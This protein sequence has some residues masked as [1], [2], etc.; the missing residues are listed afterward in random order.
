MH[1]DILIC[2]DRDEGMVLKLDKALRGSNIRFGP[3]VRNQSEPVSQNL[4]KGA[5]MLLCELPPSNFDDFDCLKWIQLTSAGYAQ[6]LDLPVLERGIRVTN[7]L[8]NFDVPIAEWNIAMMVHCH[9]HIMDMFDNQRKAVWDNDARFQGEIRG[10]VV[11][12]YGYGGIAR[13]TARM[14]KHMGLEVW[15]MTRDGTAKKRKDIYRVPGTGDPEGIL[16]DR[17][18]KPSQIEEF[19]S[20]VDFLMITMPLTPATEGIIGEKELRML[21]PSAVL[22]NPARAAIIEEQA[23]IRCLKEKWIRA[24]ALDVH[25][26]YPLPPDH[27]LWSMPNLIMTPHISGSAA[28]PNFLRRIYDIFIQNYIRYVEGKPLLNELSESQLKGL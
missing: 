8:G 23:F 10:S 6:V 1:G 7:G 12:F 14:A 13:E 22:I 25:Y 5:E 19:F 26:A 2:L 18:F 21:K 27:P 3:W 15:V 24:A 20:C 17:I 4:L 28:N 16:P 11:G 9:R